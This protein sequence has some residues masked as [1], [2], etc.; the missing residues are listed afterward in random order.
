MCRGDKLVWACVTALCSCCACVNVATAL[1]AGRMY[2]LVS[3]I[4][5]GGYG[6]GR[7]E[8]VGTNGE[9]VGY[10]SKGAFAGAP[11]GPT[12]IGYVA[13]RGGS[14]WSTTPLMPPALLMPELDAQDV[15]PSLETTLALGKPGPSEEAA[16]HLGTE[17]DV[18]LH[19]SSAPD[20]ST[21]W[22]TDGVAITSVTNEPF[23]VVYD[24][25]SQKIMSKQV[26]NT[27]QL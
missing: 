16:G 5:K 4:Y 7:I 10:F 6:V 21:N 9:S 2:E 14:G 11:S 27:S 18:L 25:A 13:S 8:A 19:S 17:T 15:S 20:I 24:G 3:P 12:R 23:T 26:K 22:S 1:P